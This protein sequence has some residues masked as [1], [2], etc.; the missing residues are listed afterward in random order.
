MINTN[1]SRSFQL[2]SGHPHRTGIGHQ[3]GG[4]NC[5]SLPDVLRERGLPRAKRIIDTYS[6]L[7]VIFAS[8]WI[9][10]DVVGSL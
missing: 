9:G 7:I 3:T 5:R 8:S 1:L 4:D 10:K 6:E 2:K